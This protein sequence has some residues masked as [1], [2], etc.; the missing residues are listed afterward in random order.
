MHPPVDSSNVSFLFISRCFA[1][2]SDH[3]WCPVSS[4]ARNRMLLWRNLKHVV[5][6]VICPLWLCWRWRER[7]EKRWNVEISYSWSPWNSWRTFPCLLG[8]SWSPC[9][10]DNDLRVYE[11]GQQNLDGSVG[12]FYFILCLKGLFGALKDAMRFSRALHNI[13]ISECV[14]QILSDLKMILS[15]I[16]ERLPEAGQA[17]LWRLQHVWQ[18]VSAGQETSQELFTQVGMALIIYHE[19]RISGSNSLWNN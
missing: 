18:T 12:I 5:V 16:Q 9:V 10:L 13:W 19:G 2:S 15:W 3:H 11:T 8:A 4:T 14:V 1:V 6:E 7:E 17:A